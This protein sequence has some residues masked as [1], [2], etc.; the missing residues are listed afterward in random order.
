MNGY[1]SSAWAAALYVFDPAQV[2]EVGRGLRSPFSDGMNPVATYDWHAQ[3]PN[4]PRSTYEAT[5]LGSTQSRPISSSVSNTGYWDAVAQEVIWVQPTS[6]GG[7]LPT[8]NVF[9]VRP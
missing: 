7:T 1:D 5:N 6:I 9:S 8:I 2:R 3:W 4:L